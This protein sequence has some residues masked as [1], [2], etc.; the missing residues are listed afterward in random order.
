MAEEDTFTFLS[1]NVDDDFNCTNR[2]F[3][4]KISTLFDPLGLLAPFT[5]KS[6]LLM[7]ETWSEGIDW[8]EKVTDS[9]VM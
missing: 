2:N 4:E 1:N 5:I 8:D 3:L 6:K 9:D 7:Q